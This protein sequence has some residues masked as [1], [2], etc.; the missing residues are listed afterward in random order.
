MIYFVVVSFAFGNPENEADPE[1]VVLTSDNQFSFY[2]KAKP[3]PLS[4]LKLIASVASPSHP[5]RNLRQPVWISPSLYAIQTTNG[6]DDIVQFTFSHDFTSIAS[7]TSHSPSSSSSHPHILRI[8]RNFSSTNVLVELS[9]GS[10]QYYP[11][12]PSSLSSLPLPCIRIASLALPSNPTVSQAVVGL[13]ATGK[14]YLNSILL[15]SLCNSFFIQGTFLLFTTTNHKLHFL[16]LAS[17]NPSTPPTME[18]CEIERGGILVAAVAFDVRV[19]L[20][21]P[22]VSIHFLLY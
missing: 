13:T 11:P 7:V 2:T 21:M 19:V 10:L 14:L 22:R 8:A 4:P 12:S 15:S 17:F 20:Q 3:I 18:S 6:K 1:V 9:D 5:L 16:P